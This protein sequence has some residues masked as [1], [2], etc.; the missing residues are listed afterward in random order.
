MPIRSEFP[1]AGSDYL[2]GQSDGWE[3]RTAF[4]GTSVEASYTMLKA[5]LKEEGYGDI[6]LPS[7]S[8]ELNLFRHPALGN[9]I[10]LFQ[11]RGYFHNPIKIFFHSHRLKTNTLILCIYN[12]T[13]EQHLLKFHGIVS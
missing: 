8:T 7:S 1:T 4:A 9:Q 3:Y 12:E 5:F 2:D 11:E 6:P 10:P 13:A